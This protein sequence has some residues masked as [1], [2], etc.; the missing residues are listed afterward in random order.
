MDQSPLFQVMF[1]WQN[2]EADDIQLPGIFPIPVEMNYDIVKF[3]L[4]LSLWEAN[5]EITG[6]LGYTTALFDRPTIERHVGY[7]QS[8]LGAM[9]IDMNRS[10]TDV[11]ILSSDEKALL[12][13]GWRPTE[14]AYPSHLCIHHTFENQVDRDP[15][16]IALVYEGQALTYR[17]LNSYA[18]G[19]AHYL[20][21]L[22]VKPETNIAICVD[23]SPAMIV[24][25]LAIL[26]AGGAYVPLDP[27]YAS[28][29]LLDIIS[30]AS[31]SILLADRI[32]CDILGEPILSSMTVIDPNT[33]MDGSGGN[34]I[35]PTL[36]PDHL[37]YVIYTSGSTGKP[38]GVM[39]EHRHVTRL[40]D[41]TEDWYQFNS[42]DTWMLTH[43]FSF[44]VSV[45]EIWGALGHGGKLIIPSRQTI[46]SPKDLS[47]LIYEQDV[48]VLNMT[49][50]AF[51]PLIK[52]HTEAKKCD[53][54]RY[55]IL[56]GEALE[57]AILKPWYDV[58]S[59]DSPRIINMYGPTEITVYATYRVM[60]AKDCDQLMSPIGVG[61][62]DTATY[63]LDSQG[64]PTPMGVIGELCIGGA[65]VTR[66]YLNRDELTSE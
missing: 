26:K 11:D 1:T 34:L 17:D 57:P 50:S 16:A 3:D 65:G 25:V 5:Y 33:L 62:P 7:L 20:I 42:N 58:R 55:I 6:V 10:I 54:L 15:D 37:A 35:V 23:R 22:G 24:G 21:D 38:K 18:N 56:A 51:R 43:S 19:L 45:W 12:L 60:K 40:F 52:Y 47:V 64:R 66:G 14:I 44:D 48:T 29:R 2:N 4:D 13:E 39:V 53:K 30:D 49:P 59:E 46:Q 61:L 8:I 31:P 32:G 63:I 27:A 41:A 36:R 28:E 9:V